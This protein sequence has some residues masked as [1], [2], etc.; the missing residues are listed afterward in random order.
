M[1]TKYLGG[2]RVGVRCQHTKS[3]QQQAK[4]SFVA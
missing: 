4:R 3:K 2:Q 1:L